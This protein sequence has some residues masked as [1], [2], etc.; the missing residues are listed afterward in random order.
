MG[1]F[2]GVDGSVTIGCSLKVPRMSGVVMNV[3]LR[4]ILEEGRT[5]LLSAS[6][7][8]AIVSLNMLNSVV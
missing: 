6:E 2:G 7:S 8:G 1:F 5:D 4:A 3:L